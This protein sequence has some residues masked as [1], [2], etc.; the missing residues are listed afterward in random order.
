MEYATADKNQF[1]F[2]LLVASYVGDNP[3]WE[4]LLSFIRENKKNYHCPLCAAS[5]EDLQKYK[6]CRKRGLSKI[7]SLFEMLNRN[8][9]S[10]ETVAEKLTYQSLLLFPPIL[11]AFPFVGITRCVDKY[12]LFRVEPMHLFSLDISRMLEDCLWN[13]LGDS[14]RTRQ[15]LKFT[16]KN[17]EW[18]LSSLRRF[19][20]RDLSSF[21]NN[22]WKSSLGLSARIKK[23]YIKVKQKLS[24]RP[25]HLKKQ[26]AGMLQ[27]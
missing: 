7:W 27:A 13:F 12:S 18:S 20:L 4:E 14:T 19:I 24:L 6:K 26:L 25:L 10:V 5:K 11:R 2:H 16:I 15:A 21:V 1:L 9:R 22:A 17:N 3:E 8:E 23:T